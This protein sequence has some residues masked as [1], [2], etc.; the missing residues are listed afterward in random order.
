[1]KPQNLIKKKIIEN[2]NFIITTHINPEADAIGSQLAVYRLLR[3]LNKE[4]KM[5]LDDKIPSN[6]DFFPEIKKIQT[7]SLTRFTP[8]GHRV[9]IVVDVPNPSRLGKIGEYLDGF[10]LVINI[11]HHVSNTRYGDIAWVEENV[12]STG[13]MIYE[14]FKITGVE[15]DYPTALY[16]YSAILTDSGGFRY[17]GTTPRTHKIVADLLD[18]GVNPS[19]V[20]SQI[21]E[22]NTIQKLHLLGDCLKNVKK[23]DRIVWVEITGRMLKRNKARSSDL[24]GIID[25]LRT[26]PDTDVA[27]V[28]QELNSEVKVTFRSRNPDIDVNKI[29]KFFE[30]GGHKMASGCKIAGEL[31]QVKRK[32]FKVIKEFMRKR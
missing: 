16:L 23:R 15:I 22:R 6:L 24:E 32:V 8:G 10:S 4:A 31:N 11:D 27:V 1:M 18:R 28:F 9:L 3:K 17:V 13:E 30:G 19:W 12:S 2:S 20:Y 26:V 5:I 29:A 7:F 14:L 25:F 21:Y